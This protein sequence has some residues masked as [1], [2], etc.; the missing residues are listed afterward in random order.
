MLTQLRIENFRGIQRLDTAIHPTTLFLGPNSSGKTTLLHAVRLACDALQLALK[1]Q[2]KPKLATQDPWVIV[3]QDLLLTNHRL[4]LSTSDWQALFYNQQTGAGVALL[5]EL[6]FDEREDRLRALRVKISCASNAQLKLSVELWLNLKPPPGIFPKGVVLGTLN[7]KSPRSAQDY[8]RRVEEAA[9]RAV[10]VPP[11]YGT[12]HEEE[13]KT[14]VVLD[15]LISS[16]DQSHAIRNLVTRLDAQGLEGLNL[17]LDEM[18]G[19]KITYRTLRDNVE[20]EHPLRLEFSNSHGPL[21]ISAAGAGLV[22]LI[23]LYS[24]LSL[25]RAQAR[26]SDLLF[27]LD[28]PEAHLHARLQARMIDK[29]ADLITKEFGAQLLLATH[30]IDMI[31]QIAS[32]EDAVLYRL[33]QDQQRVVRLQGQAEL[34]GELRQWADLT[35]FTALNFLAARRVLFHEGPTDAKLLRACAELLFRND[36]QRREQFA[37]WTLVPLDGTKDLPLAKVLGRLLRHSLL[38]YDLRAE[39]PFEVIVLLDRDYAKP[40]GRTTPQDLVE[41]IT[42]EHWVWSRHSAESVLVQQDALQEWVKAWARSR[43]Q[44]IPSDLAALVAGALQS[45]DQS[46]ALNAP[47]F[48]HLSYA[49]EREGLEGATGE[50]LR[51]RANERARQLLKQE[52]EVWQ[53]GKDRARLVLQTLREALPAE[54]RHNFPTDIIQLADRL[55]KQPI[56]FPSAAVPAEIQGLLRSMTRDA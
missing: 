37:R 24:T 9:P 51:L 33:H 34:I 43:Q 48:D 38:N 30:S 55:S 19:V 47:A 23:A 50:R 21:E 29:L 13:Y 14:R 39:Q 36:P 5:V 28:E 25:W 7:P 27:L 20:Q 11:F 31:N 15:G 41:G 4:L 45:A 18:L 53:R 52:P 35:P 42:E 16:A 46:E 17:F 3:A 12:V 10:F 56:P 22:N 49:I 44:P 26:Q 40:P 6:T 54:L 8:L 32:R 1:A 2:P